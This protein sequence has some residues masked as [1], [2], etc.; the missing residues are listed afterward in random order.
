MQQLD[1]DWWI[2][3]ARRQ[4]RNPNKIQ[5]HSLLSRRMIVYLHI[6]SWDTNHLLSGRIAYGL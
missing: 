1:S 2:T 6:V 4:V 5:T 3:E